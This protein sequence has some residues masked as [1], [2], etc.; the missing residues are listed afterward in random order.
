M[1]RGAELSDLSFWNSRCVTSWDDFCSLD[2][3]LT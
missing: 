3:K 1:N 2:L